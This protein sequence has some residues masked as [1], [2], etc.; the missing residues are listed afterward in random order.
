M[1][2]IDDIVAGVDVVMELHVL[3]NV[4]LSFYA[5]D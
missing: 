3:V 4:H 1:Q 5:N 2:L